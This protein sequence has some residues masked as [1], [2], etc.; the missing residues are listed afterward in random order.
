VKVTRPPLSPE[1]WARLR[2]IHA[3][4]LDAPEDERIALAQ[5]LCDGDSQVASEMNALLS[6]HE[7]AGSFL[8]E[9]AALA[10][11]CVPSSSTFRELSAGTV[12]AS[13]F[14]ILRHIK[15][16]GVGSV[17]EAWD[18]KLQEVVAL[19]TIRAELA[20]DPAVIEY[21]KR[22]VRNAHQVAHPNICR[23]HYLFNHDFE[24]G[25]RIWFLVME[26]IKG[27]TLFEYI[28]EKGPMSREQTLVLLEQM[29]AGLSAA[30]QHGIIHRDFKSSNVMLVEE[31]ENRYRAVITDFGLALQL[32]A[33]DESESKSVHEGTPGY[34]A[35]EQWLQGIVSPASDQYSLGV[36]L[37][38]MLTGQR[39]SP[40]DADGAIAPAVKLPAARK[41]D[42]RWEAAIRR[43]L[44]PRPEDRFPRL[45]D[46]LAAV[47]PARRLRVFARWGATVVAVVLVGALGV[48]AFD[49]A[50]QLPSLTDLQLLTPAMNFSEGPKLSSD[51]RTIA[52]ASD[53]AEPGNLDIWT[54]RLPDGVPRRVTTDPAV[55][56]S[57]SLS[58]DGRFVLFESSRKPTGIYLADLEKGGERLLVRDGQAP[59]FSP[60][61]RSFLYWTGDEYGLEPDGKIFLFDLQAGK[62]IQLASGMVDARIPVWNSDGRHI[63]FAGC[64]DKS[65]PYPAC[66]DWWV[67]SAAQETPRATGAMAALLA[68][69]VTPNVYF[70]GWQGNTVAFSAVH[71]ASMGLWEVVLDPEKARVSG[72]ARQV[73]SGDS[74]DFI[75]SSSLVGTTL[76]ICQWNPAVHVWKIEN[77]ETP[78]S[79]RLVKLTNDPEFDFAPSISHN[80]RWLIFARGYTRARRLYVS[81]TMNGTERALPFAE[82]AKNAPLVDDSGTMFAYESEDHGVK[83]IWLAGA[84]GWNRK[85]CADCA[86]PRSWFAG[87]GALLYGDAAL[88]EI[89]LQP[90]A[91]GAPRTILSVPGGGVQDATWSPENN[92]ILFTVSRQ[93]SYGQ[94]FAVRFSPGAAQP[95]SNWIPITSDS[96]FS[97]RPRWSGDGKTVY[98]LS[99]RDGYWCLWGQHFDPVP[100]R[101]RGAP[102]AVQHFHNPELNPAGIN[103][104]S[105][106]LSAAGDELYLNLLET[107]GSI[108]VGKLSRKPLLHLFK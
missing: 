15:N 21:F 39:P 18:A 25:E 108:W 82:Q 53:R 95:D 103:D 13:Q 75:I 34:V 58:P 86:A 5:L 107:G 36:V 89:R 92:H 98:Y 69:G 35:P 60:D 43:C 41:L 52:Y 47:D 50:N 19:K 99:N 56:E 57:P 67:T 33:E 30:H 79:L 49:R 11:H 72:T 55:D 45:S 65:S 29:I 9:P 1:K 27:P 31:G 38:E 2:E 91:G 23:V 59:A 61:G 64:L 88:S 42:A 77:P 70:G 93:N 12:L 101:T 6:V 81:D 97:R 63:L 90:T 7:E 26:L 74:R 94:V 80:G 84:G 51:G 16:G 96:E 105:L 40:P 24:N 48:F 54:Q 83:S 22:E 46:I 71:D 44:Q 62:S 66:R 28:R 102:F 32:R 20:S 17:Y 76:A 3:R 87:T 78:K 104:P 10:L 4:V 106:N 73:M 8:R 100:G 68:Q 85:L 37:C 14:N